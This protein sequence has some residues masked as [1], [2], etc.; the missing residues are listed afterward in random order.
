MRSETSLIQTIGRAARNSEGKVILYADQMTG[1][2][3]RAISETKRRRDIQIA[4]NTKHGITPKTILKK[5]QDIT[6][7]MESKHGKAVAAELELDIDLFKKASK[8]GKAGKSKLSKLTDEERDLAVYEKIVKI[9]E[10]EM[11]H[12][13]KELDFETAAILRDEIVVLR[14]RMDKNS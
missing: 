3:E 1:S 2:L 12:A 9:K 13:V 5:I 8:A 6:Q 7:Q 14:E 11:N 4:Y 10:K